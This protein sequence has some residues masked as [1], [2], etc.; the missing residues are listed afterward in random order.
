MANANANTD[1]AN[2]QNTTAAERAL[3]VSIRTY[4][5][6]Q[7][8]PGE[9]STPSDRPKKIGEND[10][11]RMEAVKLEFNG[12]LL[13]SKQGANG[14][15]DIRIARMG[16]VL[17]FNI[18]GYRPTG[19]PRTYNQVISMTIMEWY[20]LGEEIGVFKKWRRRISTVGECR[21][22]WC[23][24]H[25]V[26]RILTPADRN[27]ATRPP[28]G[29]WPHLHYPVPTP[30]PNDEYATIRGYARPIPRIEYEYDN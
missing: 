6:Q 30:F 11:A 3:I 1:M 22:E 4:P 21:T 8:I 25:N 29:G 27:D 18:Q 23:S 17:L 5:P 24:W 26:L 28:P 15:L 9:P 16:F 12:T 2:W 7:N 10:T 13:I 19:A 14:R 20:M